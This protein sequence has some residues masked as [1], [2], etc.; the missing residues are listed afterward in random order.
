[1]NGDGIQIGKQICD[2]CGGR[3]GSCGYH[4]RLMH[5]L[6]WEPILPKQQEVQKKQQREKSL[7]LTDSR[8][9]ANTCCTDPM[10]CLGGSA[11]STANE[12]GSVVTAVGPGLGMALQGGGQDMS[13]MCKAMQAL[14]GTGASLS[15]AAHM[16]CTGSISSCHLRIANA[17]SPV[18]CNTY[19]QAKNLCKES[20]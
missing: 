14:A 20:Q 7:V 11:L 15:T 19:V 2:E 6:V 9:Y 18:A 5:I 10:T 17:I 4:F 8:I 12:V 1:M 13:G 16:K 3:R